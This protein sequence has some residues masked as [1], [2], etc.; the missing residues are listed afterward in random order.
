[1][2]QRVSTTQICRVATIQNG[3]G[4]PPG[5]GVCCIL[6]PMPGELLATCVVDPT[7]YLHLLDLNVARIVL[8]EFVEDP[9]T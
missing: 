5:L 3:N 1:M 7:T 6:Q 4:A 8:L 2:F 9:S